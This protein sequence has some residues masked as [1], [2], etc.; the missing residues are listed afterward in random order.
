MFKC[1]VLVNTAECLFVYSHVLWS[2]K[3]QE[4]ISKNGHKK[5]KDKKIWM[6]RYLESFI[7]N[8]LKLINRQAICNWQGRERKK[9]ILALVENQELIESIKYLIVYPTSQKYKLGVVQVSMI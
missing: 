9:Y 4:V 5:P 8:V 7:L 6:H 3:I 1:R 2:F